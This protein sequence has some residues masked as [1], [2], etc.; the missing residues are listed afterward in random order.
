M[1]TRAIPVKVRLS[2][3]AAVLAVAGCQSTPPVITDI[4]NAID[5]GA[6]NA[7]DAASNVVS[8]RS[9]PPPTEGEE[10]A[11][12][13]ARDAYEEGKV[14][15]ETADYIVAVDKFTESFAAA[16]EISEPDL[17]TQVKSALYYNLGAAQLYAYDLD[18]DRTR[19]GKSKDL[20]NKYLEA[21]PDMSDEEREEVNALI[22]KGDAKA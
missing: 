7:V 4:G 2:L 9:L 3:V 8:P 5:R 12:T 1:P 6:T 17:Q 16:D 22:A 10:E 11:V 15:Y 14:A 20:L 18:G 19:L 13:R 21:N